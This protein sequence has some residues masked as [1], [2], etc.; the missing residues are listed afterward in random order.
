MCYHFALLLFFRP[1]IRLRFV[2]SNV[3][4][5]EV[6]LEAANAIS[7]LVRAYRQL[8][9]LHRTPA[10]VPYMAFSSS[11]IHLINAGSE[12][13]PLTSASQ[14]MQDI[15]DLDEMAQSHTCARRARQIL[16]RM[17]DNWTVSNAQIG[18]EPTTKAADDEECV[19]LSSSMNFFCPDMECELPNPSRTDNPLFS[20]F[21]A[22]GTPLLARGKDLET[23]GFKFENA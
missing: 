21:P 22:Q 11:I 13:S 4:P 2:D 18:Y 19:P 16:V 3:V 1:F 20:P 10:L 9:T 23:T 6:C 14:V 17:A 15:A 7:S 12:S 5:R 8:Y